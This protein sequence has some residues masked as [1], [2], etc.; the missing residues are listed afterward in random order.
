MHD[1]LTQEIHVDY[2]SFSYNA[3]IQATRERRRVI[4]DQTSA[5]QTKTYRLF[6]DGKPYEW[7]QQYITGAQ[8]RTLAHIEPNVGIFLEEHAHDKPDRQ[9]TDTSSINL[10]EP[11]VEKFYTI[12]P[13]T[14]GRW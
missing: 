9:I 1:I 11:G 8:L 4:M 13:A 14:M 2:E 3:T 12:P 10:A 6:V 7:S 5:S